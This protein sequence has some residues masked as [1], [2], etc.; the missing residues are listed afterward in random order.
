MT[1]IKAFLFAATIFSCTLAANSEC[2]SWLCKSDAFAA[3]SRILVGATKSEDFLANIEAAREALKTGKGLPNDPDVEQIL[4]Q[5]VALEP[6]FEQCRIKE[7][8]CSFGDMALM[9]DMNELMKNHSRGNAYTEPRSED[10]L[11]KLILDLQEHFGK[12]CFERFRAEYRVLD[13]EAKREIALSA[14]NN[15]LATF[16][17][18]SFMVS[19]ENAALGVHVPRLTGSSWLNQMRWLNV[20]TDLEITFFPSMRRKYPKS[21]SGKQLSEYYDE[22]VASVCNYFINDREDATKIFEKALELAKS[23]KLT[24]FMDS[25]KDWIHNYGFAKAAAGYQVCKDL[26]KVDRRRLAKAIMTPARII[27]GR[28]A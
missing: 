7:V 18:P 21:I 20:F 10:R 9:R 2:L 26:S 27:C 13:I 11:N 23:V 5:F 14:F 3:A 24:R 25:S 1:P 6:L 16:G 8:S 22:M 15:L 28:G 19:L 4:K 12:I 17:S